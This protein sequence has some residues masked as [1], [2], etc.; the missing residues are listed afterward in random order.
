[1]RVSAGGREFVR[2]VSPTRSY[3]AQVERA[4]TI[5]LGTADSIDRIEVEWAGGGSTVV[6]K[7]AIDGTV[8]IGPASSS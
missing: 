6:E 7:P 3:L 5:G 8:R 1:M 2:T 4:L